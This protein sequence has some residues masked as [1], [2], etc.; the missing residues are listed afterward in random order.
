M[1][2]TACAQRLVSLL[3]QALLSCKEEEKQLEQQIKECRVLLGSWKIKKCESEPLKQ[4][5]QKKDPEDRVPSK[6]A[7][8]EVELLNKVLEKA[9][10]VRGNSSLEPAGMKVP[11]TSQTYPH[12][13]KRPTSRMRD[14]RKKQDSCKM[15]PPYKT[16]PEKK[17][18]LRSGRRTSDCKATVLPC[19]A[20]STR[21]NNKSANEKQP[22][23]REG[24]DIVE[25]VME[26]FVSASSIAPSM[27]NTEDSESNCFTLQHKGATLKLPIEYRREYARNSRLWDKFYDIQNIT[28]PSQPHFM[29]MLQSTFVPGSP[30]VSLYELEEEVIRLKLT[31][32]AMKKT[33]DFT[34]N[35]TEPGPYHWQ[36]Y[37]TLL[38]L[39]DLQKELSSNLLALQHLREDISVYQKW[40]EGS[41]TDNSNPKPRSCPA[42][43]RLPPLLLIYNHVDELSELTRFKLRIQELQQ[44]IHLQ[45]VLSTE[46]LAEAESRCHRAPESWILFRAIYTQ[47]CEGGENFPVLIREDN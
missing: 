2:S 29:Q 44:K 43:V 14:L 45:K 15:N 8:Q 36:N 38:I 34:E 30:R 33:I 1:L 40:D 7:M 42:S 6:E 41:H 28:P 10:K 32:R 16:N 35:H 23:A 4:E 26:K 47:L 3:N 17:R 5:E 25:N 24:S 19:S 46:L 27:E 20:Q 11:A 31:L 12:T 22:E 18:I 39:E 37:R 21:E 13:S 9:L